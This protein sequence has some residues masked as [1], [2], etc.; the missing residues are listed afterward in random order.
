MKS[1]LFGASA[2]ALICASPS[3]GLPAAPDAPRAVT[4]SGAVSGMAAGP[5]V[6]FKAI[7]YAAPPVGPLRWKPPQPAPRW[8]GVREATADG[9]ACSQAVRPDGR[10]NGG[11]Y[12]GP[13][14]EDCLTLNVTA[15]KGARR[16]PVMVWLFGGGNVFGADDL[17]SYDATNFARDGVVVVAMNYRL[18]P[19]GFFAHPALTAEAGKTAPLVSYG[20]MDQIAALKWVKRNIA[21]FGGDP[22]NVT[23]FGESAGGDDTL[24]LMTV[25][26]ARGLFDRAIVESGGGWGKPVSLAEREA[27]GAALATKLGLPGEKATAEQLR[28][29]PADALISAGGGFSGPA[30]DGRLMHESVTQ[31]FARGDEANLPLIIGSNSFEASLIALFGGD[32]VEVAKRVP[33]DLRAAYAA[34][35]PDD[36]SLAYATFTDGVM[37]APARWIAARR[38]ASGPA[39]LYYFSYLPIPR[40]GIQVGANHAGEIPYAFDSQEKIPGRAKLLTDS[41]RAV[42]SMMHACWVAFAKH[43]RPDCKVGEQPWPAYTP[44]SDQLAEFGISSGVRQHFRKSELDAQEKAHADEFGR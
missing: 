2:A 21:A 41:D 43:G 10:P 20:L 39:W 18:G 24:A 11:G 6:V 22:H 9:P 31:A 4:Q 38:S 44:Q 13:T 36:K 30:V 35:A 27:Q 14:S 8:S 40:R 15:P 34:E 25:P 42:T 12:A 37:G 3:L 26:A 23:L 33:P 16:A 19:L 17:P 28:A 5:A 32:P 29:L 7:P 1:L